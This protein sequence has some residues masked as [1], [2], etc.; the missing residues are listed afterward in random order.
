MQRNLVETLLGA[1]VL[2]IA[3]VFLV[4]FSRSVDATGGDGYRLIA[5]FAKADGVETGTSVR[6]SGVPVGRVVSL[7]LIPDTFQAEVTMLIRSDVRLPRD[8]AAVI[9]SAGLLDGKYITLEPGGDEETLSPGERVEFTQS[10]P[11]I[12]QL[13]GQAIFNL[14][15]KNDEK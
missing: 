12:E 10:P 11:G 1:A 9:A 3:A 8:T 15:N 5:A 13:L 2:F 14:S 4:Y 7:S 6:I